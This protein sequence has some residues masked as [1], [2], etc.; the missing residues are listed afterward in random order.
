M[1][2]VRDRLRRLDDVPTP[3]LWGAI[4]GRRPGAPIRLGP[5]TGGRV[6][7]AIVAIAVAAAATL[8]AVD[9]LTPQRSAVVSLDTSTWSLHEVR[10]L[11]LEFR[12]PPGWH[13]QTFNELIGTAGFAGALASNEQHTFEHPELGA[14]VTTAWSMQ[15]V[16]DDAV[17]ISIERVDAVA[18][19]KAPSDTPLPLALGDSRRLT[20]YRPS[21]AW[22]HL[23]LPFVLGGR[24]DSVRVWFGP[25]STPR[26]REIARLIVASIAPLQRESF[27]GWT[28]DVTV[29]HSPSGALEIAVGSVHEAA[30]NDAHPWI[31]HD[32]ILRNSGDIPLYFEDTRATELLGR[33][34]PVLFAADR[35]CGHGDPGNGQPLE[36]DVCLAYLDAFTIPAHRAERREVTLFKDLRGLAPLGPGEYVFNKV[37]RYRIGDSKQLHEV[38]VRLVYAIE[39]A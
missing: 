30:Q 22:T 16:P 15:D 36:W 38:R 33:P 10:P 18:V 31:Q 28:V 21:R 34:E 11:R 37:Y 9:R 26:D 13:L 25:R 35:G 24:G 12:Y 39:R 2:E 4:E 27:D 7:A 32:V 6:G 1:S 20:S 29:Q 3:E 5:S 23:W 14:E 19:P 17:V 8:F